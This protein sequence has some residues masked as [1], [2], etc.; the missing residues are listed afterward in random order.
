VFFDLRFKV[1]SI[2]YS[3][4]NLNTTIMFFIWR[5]TIICCEFKT[6]YDASS[7]WVNNIYLIWFKLFH[8]I[9]QITSSTQIFNIFKFL[10]EMPHPW[11]NSDTIQKI[12]FLNYYHQNLPNFILYILVCLTFLIYTVSKTVWAQMSLFLLQTKYSLLISSWNTD[13]S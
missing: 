1:P 10:I 13:T 9:I 4:S 3:Q 2:N 7:Y 8:T 11:K 6:F 12:R 5:C